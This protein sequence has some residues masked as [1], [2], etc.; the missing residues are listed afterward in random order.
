MSTTPYRGTYRM[1]A[2]SKAFVEWLEQQPPVEDSSGRA[3]A[4]LHGLAV[5]AGAYSASPL[6]LTNLLSDLEARGLVERTLNG[7]RTER[8][9]IDSVWLTAR[10]AS[11]EAEA[12]KAE[13]RERDAVEVVDPVEAR[14]VVAELAEV[15][16]P[17][18][19]DDLPP[20]RPAL[21]AKVHLALDVD[22]ATAR[23]ILDLVEGTDALRPV[24]RREVQLL[25]A[26]AIDK[27]TDRLAGASS[28]V[29]DRLAEVEQALAGLGSAVRAQPTTNGTTTTTPER[30]DRPN[31]A[32]VGRRLGV[33]NSASR[34]LLADLAGDG[35]EL[36]KSSNSHVRATKDGHQPF[37]VS[38][39]PSDHRTPKNDRARAR[40]NGANV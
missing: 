26:R 31:P 17:A 11:A 37:S 39:T 8:I 36:T 19:L 27:A 13:L 23:L 4:K 6:A 34:Q 25:I 29:T 28:R 1:S 12:A 38:S 33:K 15:T 14:E 10:Q 21:V 35:W 20:P 40:K 32:E 18:A 7:K 22:P 3:T 30:V 16:A 2:K 24:D 5:A 9:A